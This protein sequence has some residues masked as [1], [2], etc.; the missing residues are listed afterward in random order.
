MLKFVEAKLANLTNSNSEW[1]SHIP[2][3]KLRC[4][5]GLLS[6]VAIQGTGKVSSRRHWEAG[7]RLAKEWSE[8]RSEET[9]AQTA[10][11]RTPEPTSTVC[12]TADFS[13]KHM[14]MALARRGKTKWMID[15][16]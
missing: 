11:Q 13:P 2:K 6:W 8:K 12:G 4:V 15:L 5:N 1:T 9:R 14:N 3:V 16:A 10:A 7:R